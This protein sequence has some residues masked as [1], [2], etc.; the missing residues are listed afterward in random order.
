MNRLFRKV[1]WRSTITSACMAAILFSIPAG[2]YIYSATYRSSWLLYLGCFLF[3]AVIWV[4]TLRESRKKANNES[5]VALIFSSHVTTLCGIVLSCII[6]FLLLIILVPGYLAPGMAGKVMTGEP[7]N[8]VADKTGGMSFQLFM[9]AT[10]IN[11]SVG[12]FTSIILPFAVKQNQ[13]R[14]NRDPAP[15]HQ[16]GN[17]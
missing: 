1:N 13:K 14:D 6:C 11:F 16:R 17:E 15:L 5:T 10:M 4:H 3:F 8:V 9:A 2:I 7:V 12:S